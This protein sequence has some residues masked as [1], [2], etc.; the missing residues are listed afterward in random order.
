MHVTCADRANQAQP[1]F[2]SHRKKTRKIICPVLVLP[3]ARMRVSVV[4]CAGSGIISSGEENNASISAA[5]TPCFRHLARFPAS[6]SKPARV[7]I[8]YSYYT[9]VYTKTTHNQ[10]DEDRPLSLEGEV[11]LDWSH[12]SGPRG[13][14]NSGC[15]RTESPE[16]YLRDHRRSSWC[17]AALR[18]QE[19]RRE[20]GRWSIDKRS[21]ANDQ[22]DE[23]RFTVFPTH[24]IMGRS[25]LIGI[26]YLGYV[27]VPESDTTITYLGA[28]AIWKF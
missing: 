18:G 11:A 14:L 7:S 12:D 24:P 26:G 23:Y 9:N 1:A 20:T 5:D 16:Q 6:Q 21:R 4:E 19:V 8:I 17:R 2:P 27:E 22:T 13:V 28:G 10:E 3:S 15:P 25:D